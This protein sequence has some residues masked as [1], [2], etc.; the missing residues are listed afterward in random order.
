MTVGLVGSGPAAA[1]VEAALGDV[2]VDTV[3]VEQDAIAEFDLAV[4]TGQAGDAVFE[5][6]NQVALDAGQRWLAVE[7]GGVGGFPVVDAAV[8][9]FGPDTGCYECLS[10]RVS[11]NLDPQA[12]PTAAPPSHT[13]RFAGAVAGREAARALVDDGG[14]FGR[15]VEI[16]HASREFLPLPDCACDD[17]QTHLP[18]HT[19]VERDLEASLA[20]AERA[21]DDR[22]G[23]IQDVGEAESFPV[24][25]YLAHSCDTSGFSDV[26]ASRDAAGV[27]AGWDRA[28]MKALGEGLE[29]YCA[30]VYRVDEFETA[31]ET[32]VTDA[33]SP[34]V[35][36]CVD[37]HD[38]TA[39][40]EWV[41]GENLATG[42]PVH[43]P[44]EFVYYPPPSR[45]YCSPV[46]TGLGLG[47]GGVEAL[48][49]GLYEVI[50][51]D[52]SMLSWYSTFEPLALEV[53][54]EEFQT[55]VARADS[56]GL[57]VSTLLL[58]Q[59]VDVPAVAVAVHRDEW[60]KFAV[61]SGA[62]LDVA[63]A[64]RSA[65]AEAL[66]NWMELRG[67]GREDAADATGA[68]GRYA[69]LPPEAE[70]FVETD[71]AVPAESVGPDEVPTGEDELEEVLARLDDADLSAFATRTTT[72]DVAA[73][74]FEAV[75]AVIP[76]A[77]PLFFHDP[78]F[79]ERAETVPQE[80]GFEPRLDR[81]HHPFP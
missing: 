15:V 33:V 3:S 67:M 63:S 49:A 73:L 71:G 72:R 61:G 2:D 69:D 25:Y 52:A 58:T 6:A 51:R 43:L 36:T 22:L 41:R 60:P 56:Q 28:F 50:E 31:P 1:A 38:P 37:D 10:G 34:A 68:I 55:L 27:A 57:S 53:A 23:L 12:E 54:D 29:R 62:D 9:G 64:A 32:A 5:R 44:A 74:G 39:Q 80:M 8:A 79:G 7:L 21:V 46:T 16:P 65:L 81:E 20:R 24:P 45:R 17:G 42:D 18:A 77:Q 75:R 35:F 70:A 14:L 26:S 30:G 66:Q 40:I 11:A 19:H 47:N 76:Q 13:A 48:L 78:V 59:D 4:V